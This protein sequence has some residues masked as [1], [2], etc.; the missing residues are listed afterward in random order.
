[1]QTAP[2]PMMM[3]GAGIA[4]R[5]G[6][7]AWRRVG[8]LRP[9]PAEHVFVAKLPWVGVPTTVVAP[10]GRS[11]AASGYLAGSL[12]GARGDVIRADAARKPRASS[13]SARRQRAAPAVEVTE[14]FD[15][16][17]YD[18]EFWISQVTGPSV[19]QSARLMVQRVDFSDPLGVDTSLRGA[20]K[21]SGKSGGR[22]TL[23]DYALEVKAQHPRKVLLIRVGEFYEAIGYDAVMLVM[24]AGLNPMGLTGVPRAGCPLVKVQETLDRLT[25][26]GFS[27]VVCEEVPVM[28]R[29]GTRA[30]PKERYV[31]AIITPASPQYVVGAADNGDDVEFDGAAPPPVI[32]VAS[33]AV[34]YTLIAVEPDLRRVTVTEGLTSESAAARLAAGGL[35]P[36]LYVHSSMDAG[37]AGRSTGVAGQTRR[38]RLEVGNILSA[39]TNDGD[40]SKQR[41]DGKDPVQGL[42]N[43]VKREYGMTVD[44]SFEFVGIN[45]GREAAASKRPRPFPLTLSTAQQ[46][47]VLPTRSVPPLLSH[48]LPTSS[49]APAGCRAYIQELLLHP[50]PRDTAA[51]ISEA[52]VLMST[53]LSPSDGGVPRLEVVPPQKITKLLWKKEATHVFFSEISAMASA[54]RRTLEH[55]SNVV[56]RAGEL[57]LNPTALKTGR[58]VT[59]ESLVKACREAEEVIGAVVAEE[60][61]DKGDWKPRAQVA[62][63]ID[64][65]A[66]VDDD[67]YNELDG[68]TEADLEA[69]ALG[70]DA[71]PQVDY[72]PRQ[73]L[74][75]NEPWRGRVRRDRV[76]SALDACETAA[77]ELAEVIGRDL[78]PLIETSNAEHQTRKVNRC[79][80][81]HDQRNNSLWLRHLPAA[82]AKRVQAEGLIDLKHPVDRYG[83]QIG[84]RWTTLAVET[85]LDRY[86][87]TSFEA[88]KEVAGALRA[89]AGD[90]ELLVADLVSAATFS[91]VATAVSLHA[92]H[93]VSRGWRPAQ[94]LP[95]NDAS[96]PWHLTGLVPF[97]MD[98]DDAVVN[99]VLLDGI[100]ILTGPNMAGK[101]TVLRATA[102][103]ALLASCR[104]HCPVKSA[105]VPFFDS[106]IVRMSSTDSP[107]EGLSSYAVEMAEV[108]QMLDVVTAKSAVFIDELGRGT[109]A[110]HGTAMA[111]A[112]VEELDRSGARGIFAT[113]L[114][115]VLDLGLNLS[116]FAKRMMMETRDDRDG[117]L[118]P[119]LRMVLGECRESLALQTAT[120]MGVSDEVVQR[121]QALLAQ[122]PETVVVGKTSSA[123]QENPSPASTILAEA[124]PLESLRE[125]LVSVGALEL[126]SVPEAG[127]VH[128][129][130]VPP[131]AARAWSCVYVLRRGDGWAYC[132]E[133]DDLGGRLGAHRAT[134]A[135]EGSNEVECAFIAVP[136]EGGGK[137]RARALESRVIRK[138]KAEGI[139][140]LSGS[141]ARNTSFGSA[142]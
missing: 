12:R 140:L 131:P 1:M 53:G 117:R 16:G 96:T 60:V 42:L 125:L 28:H 47:G 100:S 76:Q 8:V 79:H 141:D 126:G 88:G 124:P 119:T 138:L 78:V 57:L 136:R 35:A 4:F 85:A 142:A 94:L 51:A 41:Y 72:V 32:G 63:S 13:S 71:P 22:K 14:P 6:L 105:S 139:P 38:L 80:L 101:S 40:Y 112:V 122:I 123:F 49:G 2:S 7:A 129:D 97:W 135:R 107:A 87:V 23:Y 102:A 58:N 81:E 109:E 17:V 133:T 134:A 43:L 104:L 92:R 62:T 137:S 89:L 68:E 108:G 56:R 77:R 74:R 98:R 67:E 111:G 99:D 33:T 10:S 26:R 128:V 110:R 106:L 84:D 70:L 65:D 54:V 121:S 91:T 27:A 20:S 115:G 15:D 73:F 29:Y 59:K 64:V 116:P 9:A 37:H 50:P 82:V 69:L 11:F 55:D 75:I 30:P 66:E 48:A 118:R 19:K 127:I 3:G 25:S 24:H 120:D 95:A 39:G 31:A 5:R 46:L 44:Q 113:H 93:A 103:A 90:L 132:G 114:H 34:G 45:G 21:G 130:D 36:P 61:L 83:K 18:R 52:C 86:R